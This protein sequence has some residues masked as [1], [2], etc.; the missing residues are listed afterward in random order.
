VNLLERGRISGYQ[1]FALLVIT[2]LVPVVLICPTVTLVNNPATA[3]V[4]DIIGSLIAVLLVWLIVHLGLKYP[5]Q[6][7]IGYT[8]KLLG[9]IVG[10]LVGFSILW[11]YFMIAFSVLRTLGETVGTGLLEETPIQVFLI[12]AAF[13]IAN[14]ARNGMEINARIAGITMPIIIFLLLL[15]VA[16]TSNL[17]D[18]GYLRPFFFGEGF[19]EL[20]WPSASVLSFYTEYLIIGMLLP[21]LNNPRSAMPLSMGAVLIIV[22]ILVMHCLGMAAVFGPLFN[23]ASHPA[24]AL[25]RMVSLGDFFER[26]ESLIAVVWILGAGIKVC[27]FFWATAVGLAQLLDLKDFRPLAYPLGALMVVISILSY[28][29]LIGLMDVLTQAMI[30]YSISFLILILSALYLAAIIKNYV[31][32]GISNADQG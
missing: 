2:R 15:V 10:M 7:I 27:L 20:I 21:Y 26:I 30:V 29:S 4:N 5:D 8:K 14:S 11:F 25:A 6:T 22:L 24:F 13:L 16:S 12:S 23:S 18:P 19:G 31:G 9:P 17:M 32:D 1:Y 28:E 3:W